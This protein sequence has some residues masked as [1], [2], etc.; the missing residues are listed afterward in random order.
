MNSILKLY[1]LSLLLIIL[2][3]FIIISNNADWPTLIISA[4]LYGLIMIRVNK[5]QQT[6]KNKRKTNQAKIIHLKEQ[7]N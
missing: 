1:I 3:I 2:T 7:N 5:L 4:V 6:Q